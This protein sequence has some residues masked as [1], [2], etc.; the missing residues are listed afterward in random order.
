MNGRT[1]EEGLALS[2][3]RKKA[4]VLWIS[5]RVLWDV[6]VV[7]A[8]VYS[9]H[10]GFLTLFKDVLHRLMAD[11]KVAPSCVCESVWKSDGLSKQ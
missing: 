9:G 6:L 1:V 10:F 5:A 7:D 2:P 3:H 4:R 11:S 8:G